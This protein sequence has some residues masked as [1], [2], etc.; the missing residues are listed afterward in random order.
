[1]SVR[2]RLRSIVDSRRV[3]EVCWQCAL[4]KSRYNSTSSSRV[5]EGSPG[6]EGAFAGQPSN[7]VLYP[8]SPG[9]EK[10][11]IT[12]HVFDKV[13]DP[14]KYSEAPAN[15]VSDTHDYLKQ[16]HNSVD[17]VFNDALRASF[18]DSSVTNSADPC[19]VSGDQ[20]SGNQVDRASPMVGQVHTTPNIRRH[21]RVQFESRPSNAKRGPGIGHEQ[22]AKDTETEWNLKAGET[23]PRTKKHAATSAKRGESELDHSTE[24]QRPESGLQVQSLPS[25]D[26][27]P[28]A[29]ETYLNNEDATFDFIE[30]RRRRR[31]AATSGRNTL[32]GNIPLDAGLE[33][34]RLRAGTIQSLVFRRTKTA[35]PLVRRTRV[36]RD[37][38]SLSGRLENTA[39]VS[40]HGRIHT[41]QRQTHEQDSNKLELIKYA[42]ISK[43]YPATIKK[44]FFRH[45]SLESAMSDDN[46]FQQT[47]PSSSP[48]VR[49]LTAGKAGSFRKIV[50]PQA[51]NAISEDSPRFQPRTPVVAL[52]NQE[53]HESTLRGPSRQAQF[54]RKGSIH[55]MGSVI[56]RVAQKVDTRSDSGNFHDDLDLVLEKLS[57][58]PRPYSQ[59]TANLLLSSPNAQSFSSPAQ[60]QSRPKINTE[61]GMLAGA[62]GMTTAHP[63]HP[64]FA[65]TV[66][67]QF[68]DMDYGAPQSSTSTS[69]LS[70]QSAGQT[71]REHL[72]AWKAAQGDAMRASWAGNAD[73][74]SRH[75]GLLNAISQ[76]GGDEEGFTRDIPTEDAPNEDVDLEFQLSTNSED[77]VLEIFHQHI[78]FRRGDLVEL[79]TGYGS[80]LGV[81]VNEVNNTV[82]IYTERG[83]WHQ[84]DSK[85]IMFSVPSF[86]E[87][88]E[89]LGLLPHLPLQGANGETANVPRDIGFPLIERMMHFSRA[90]DAVFRQYGDRL[91]RAYGILSDNVRKD[92][93]SISL[94]D[95][96]L[97]IYQ[98]QTALDLT[99]PML[100]ILHRTLGR[101]QNI[102]RHA[103]FH[104]M[105]PRF[106]VLPRETLASVNAVRDWLRAYQDDM[107]NEA[108]KA[109]NG[110]NDCSSTVF[111]NPIATFA[112]K[113]R[114]IVS[115]N[116]QNRP[117]SPAGAVGPSLTKVILDESN[118]TTWKVS[119]EHQ[120]PFNRE[121]QQIIGLLDVWAAS[122]QVNRT[123]SL[124]SLGPMILR[125]IGIYEDKGL[126]ER[127]AF[128][129]LQELGVVKPWDHY[130]TFLN[131]L[132]LP[133]EDPD[134]PGSVL[135]KEAH[136]SLPRL[137]LTLD[138]SMA[139]LRRDWGDLTVFCID[140]EDTV[141]RDDGISLQPVDGDPSSSW[142]HVHVANPS[143]FLSKDSPVARYAHHITESVYLPEMV[144]H[145]LDMGFSQ[146]HLSLANGRPC[147]TFSA[148]VSAEGD[149]IEK[150]ITHG[151]INNV[152]HLSWQK[153]LQALA[154]SDNASL[155]EHRVSLLHVGQMD[156]VSRPPKPSPTNPEAVSELSE[157]DV[158][159][160]R[161]LHSI[162]RTLAR[163]RERAGAISYHDSNTRVPSYGAKVVDLQVHISA[164]ES[165]MA[166]VHDH[167]SRCISGDPIIAISQVQGVVGQVL[168]MVAEF[169]LLAGQICASWCLERNIPIPYRGIVRNPDPE[170]SPEVYRQSVL[171]PAIASQGYADRSMWATYMMLVGKA[172]SSS[173]PLE[174]V[175][176]GLPA[177]CKTTSP[178]RRHGDLIAHWQVEAALR[179]EHATKTSLV[180]HAAGAYDTN[181]ILPY[182]RREIEDEIR[183]MCDQ[184]RKIAR[185]RIVASGH[186]ITQALHRAFYY[187]EAPLP[188]TLEFVVRRIPDEPSLRPTWGM[189]SAWGMAAFI[190]T[191]A[192]VDEAGGY[193]INDIWEAEIAEVSPN[194][195]R[196]SLD[197]IRLIRREGSR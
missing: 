130:S 14:A 96:A 194:N 115:F 124:H 64:R 98:K 79:G 173:R 154:P 65:S 69:H 163:R 189:I 74:L 3:S 95:A 165:N 90:S 153:A 1:M 26:R 5:Q 39:F 9:R 183:H 178:L 188:A 136:E 40:E 121:E 184:E 131:E 36:L 77:D 192:V 54:V 38:V 185:A 27:A 168:D 141:V 30:R 162:S 134:H 169:M 128:T 118:S 176:L 16:P 93:L 60:S 47:Q 12:E 160:L 10:L 150:N 28:V 67:N 123:S 117:L 15:E 11:R 174:H 41:D 53:A 152:R 109:L 138:D 100:L 63:S 166:T 102:R 139:E 157:S 33:Q 76:S 129:L 158:N 92:Q 170:S 88:D 91:N 4:R 113:V 120:E 187:D 191:D 7:N 45:N 132:G 147:M 57:R 144:Y 51:S 137:P 85:A 197:P 13:T 111:N 20:E 75:G 55:Q 19:V 17:D 71:I 116:R 104:R 106:R 196:I 171:E 89:L 167:E 190:K 83:V 126:G 101:D 119:E 82:H 8:C 155:H 2:Q 78:Y 50:G 161:G 110:D 70:N 103:H 21:P 86:V 177:Y 112:A 80:F 149:I 143:A 107:V 34:A 25:D 151:I 29:S 125:A 23:F 133:N 43:A 145:M 180:G 135:L 172:Y 164:A 32:R 62:R 24:Q 186:W 94:E 148:K 87:P 127:T 52:H 175:A 81:I 44:H 84:A 105:N 56:R 37:R 108:A 59:E 48:R 195:S 122:S 179:H 72:K 31:R 68:P 97:R 99:P 22:K 66:A 49:K 18:S 193:R 156:W 42:K 73:S 181:D 58:S 61:L 46:N 142:I 159:A 140:G 182:S 146:K 35:S 6:L 114:R